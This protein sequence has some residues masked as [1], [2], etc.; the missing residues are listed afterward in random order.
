[1]GMHDQRGIRAIHRLQEVAMDPLV[2]KGVEGDVLEA[3]FARVA[4]TG[5]FA[6]Q[7][8]RDGVQLS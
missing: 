6:C 7:A 3:R 5:R 8:I 4:R 1:M 2:P